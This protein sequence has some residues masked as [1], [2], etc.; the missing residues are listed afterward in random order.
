MVQPL[1]TDTRLK[2]KNATKILTLLIVKCIWWHVNPAA[3]PNVYYNIEAPLAWGNYST[4]DVTK[5]VVWIRELLWEI[6]IVVPD[7]Q[8][9][10]EDYSGLVGK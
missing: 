2:R 5:K 7:W 8:K 4:A 10:G 3:Y 6:E 9:C 1:L